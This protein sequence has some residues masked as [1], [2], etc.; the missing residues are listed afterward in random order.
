M[1][2]N[3]AFWWWEHAQLALCE[4]GTQWHSAH[5]VAAH[6]PLY[7][8][9]SLPMFVP[10]TAWEYLEQQGLQA[11]STR[12][13]YEV[14]MTIFQSEVTEGRRQWLCGVSHEERRRRRSNSNKSTT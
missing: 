11:S 2:V 14:L 4:V 6:L 7:A 1:E 13:A 12:R 10:P 9:A 3:D 5:H 8:V